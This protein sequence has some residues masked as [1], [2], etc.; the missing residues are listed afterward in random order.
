MIA[1]IES[2]KA[3]A[4]MLAEAMAQ[5]TGKITELPSFTEPVPKKRTQWIDPD[6]RLKRVKP[7]PPKQHLTDGRRAALE[8]L[9]RRRR[10]PKHDR[11]ETMT[12]L[13]EK[14]GIARSTLQRRLSQGMSMTEALQPP[15]TKRN[16]K[17]DRTI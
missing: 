11:D 13:A 16:R 17:N 12:Q 4:Q 6:S 9:H 3:D 14:H 2:R 8:E 10:T 1:T 5:Y 15:K 7:V